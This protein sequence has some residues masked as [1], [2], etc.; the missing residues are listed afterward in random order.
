M[1]RTS[2][3]II[4]TGGLALP[5][6]GD[7]RFLATGAAERLEVTPDVPTLKELGHDLEPTTTRGIAMPGGAPEEAQD[8]LEA[9]L[10]ELSQD[11]TF[12]ERIN[13]AG[14]EVDFRGQEAY[15]EYSRT[16]TPRSSA[17]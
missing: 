9:A 12:I 3:N 7:L 8:Q 15:S 5:A 4:A 2:K 16:W 14:A 6:L 11:E 17:W 10:R 1:L 13:N